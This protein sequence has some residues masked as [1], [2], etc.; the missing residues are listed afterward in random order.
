MSDT[1]AITAI[2]YDLNTSLS[3]YP[4]YDI[5]AGEYK[6]W[7]SP[8]LGS[9]PQGR[10]YTI[11]GVM[12]PDNPTELRKMSIAELVMC[13]CLARATKVEEEIINIM[14]EMSENTNI[15]NQMTDIENQL[16]EGKTLNNITGNYS[17][18]GQTFTSPIE[19]LNMVF[20]SSNST[21]IQLRSIQTRLQNEEP[22]QDMTVSIKY[23]GTL[24]TKAKDYILALGINPRIGV[25][26]APTL[27]VLLDFMEHCQGLTEAQLVNEVQHISQYMT[28]NPASYTPEDVIAECESVIR[29][30]L[31]P[32]LK[33]YL[34]SG[35]G[36]TNVA[37]LSTDELITKMESKMDSLNSFSQEKM[38]ELQSATNKRDQSYD[39]ITNVLKSLNTVQVGI[40][41]NI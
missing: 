33:G 2:P 7:A 5:I 6:P 12:D 26:A 19:F 38:I 24:F 25:A 27:S 20:N 18:Y 16:L 35:A 39:L 1:R 14:A 22:L 36:G 31:L 37:L 13:I 17:Y 28:L 30:Y 23:N 4:V 34:N 3:P 11:E 10:L 29:V 21:Y 40:A 15:L 8:P 9:N 32:S 41:N